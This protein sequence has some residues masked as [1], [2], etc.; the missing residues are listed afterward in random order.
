MRRVRLLGT[1]LATALLLLTLNGC[2]STQY[3][4]AT[5]PNYGD[6][7]YKDDLAQCRKQN[8][9]VVTSY[10]Y[11]YRTE[12]QVDEPKAQSCMAELGWQ[13]VTR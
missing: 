13:P 4:N 9:K 6:A 2:A 8:S 1:S 11:D 12:V 7:E 10:G 3:K 5:H